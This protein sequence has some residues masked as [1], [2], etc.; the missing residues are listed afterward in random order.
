MQ[1][2][3]LLV[4]SL[5]FALCALNFTL[6]LAEEPPTS[7]DLIV[8]AWAAHGK[9]DVE[10]TF[11]Y[12]QEIIDLY[13]QEA[14]QQ[15]ASLKS[16]PKSKDEINAVA[17]L[18]NVATAYFIQGESYRDQEKI[19]QSVEAF[20]TV[21]DKYGFA[22]AWDPRGWY[23]QIAKAAKESIIKLKPE[24]YP[25]EAAE[26]EKAAKPV[27]QL[28]TKVVLYDP[29]KEEF[30]NYEKFGKFE[31]A[32][33]KDYKYVVT[34]QEGLSAAVGEGV[35]PNTTSLRWDP[36][37]KK[38]LK[39]K[40]L[41]G[42]HWDFVH[43]PDLEAAFLKWA[44][45]PE[46]PGVRL[47]YTGLILEKSGLIA[48][49]I[50]CYYAIVVHFPG[51]YGWTYW[52]TPWYV[53]Q[54][55]ISKIN[56][57]LRK[58]PSLGY[59]LVDADIKIV[60]GYDHDISNDGVITNPGRFV[61]ISAWEKLKKKLSAEAPKP[62]R[63]LGSGKV[64][65]VQ[66]DNRDWQLIVDGKPYL[67]RGITYAPT[68]VGE[69]PDNGT[70]TNWMENDFNKNGKIDGPY[71]SFVDKNGNNR[72]DKDEPAVGDFKLMQE[73]GVNTIRQYHQ[74][75]AVNNE[76]LRD[77][78]KTY[79]IRVIMGDFLGKYAIGSG[80]PW[81]P[82]TDYNNQEQ[83]E[84]ML[85]SVIK[86]VNQ[87][88]DEPYILFWL[89]GN[90]NVYGYGCNAD[91]EPDAFFKFANE[92]A[93][94]IKEIDPEHPVAICSGDVLY[95]DKYAKDCPDIDIFGTNA[96]RGEEG[97]GLLWRQLKEETDKPV[98][99]TEFGCP[100]YAQNK[101][102][103]TAQALQAQYHQGAWEDIEGNAAFRDGEGNS[104]GGVVFEW[105][106]EW[107]KAYEPFVHDAKGLFT[108]PFP[109]GYMHEEWLGIC[110][111]GDGKSSPFLRQLRQS[112]NMYKKNW[113]K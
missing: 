105:L 56:Y 111:Q 99:I 102:L 20:K 33:T 37:Y 49:A 91:K 83:K 39:E 1:N 26:M 53:G 70:L 106:D 7:G 11:K 60:N 27:S 113:H 97:F 54:A 87:F 84:K 73:M 88:K 15:Q 41:E 100:A 2:S 78:Y 24:V 81:D 36:E 17:S 29:G 42:S 62:K 108:G 65:L 50:K 12:T 9:K 18:N 4:L 51:S 110:G 75:S 10:A 90:E 44:T 86:M 95:L 112:Y 93:L 57:L 13:A 30:V 71:D 55:A 58:N 59:R 67:V 96:Y 92:V 72:Q 61:K 109:D 52:H 6:S 34:D 38:A 68:K 3:K 14:D 40:R 64:H 85:E 82:G 74:P 76:L 31:N 35:Y 47:Y 48:Q 101:P 104:I 63:Q 98:F 107:W 23:W 79:G 32:G 43:S 16:L 22:Q 5:S 25:Q 45:A 28:P 77:L 80:A 69:S 94:K 19:D 8:K 89:L 66:Y 46:P 21:V 103:E